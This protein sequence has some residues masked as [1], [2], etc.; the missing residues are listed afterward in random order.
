MAHMIC[1]S[2]VS[3]L[4][5]PAAGSSVVA[6]QAAATTN[7]GVVVPTGRTAVTSWYDAGLR[8]KPDVAV[9]AAVEPAGEAAVVAAATYDLVEAAAPAGFVWGGTFVF[10][11][12]DDAGT[13]ELI[14]KV[15]PM[16]VAP[17]AS[18]AGDAE[19]VGFSEDID[20]T[21]LI[22]KERIGEGTQ[23]EVLL[24]E[25]PGVGPVAVKVGFKE[26]AIARE[27]V[28]LSALCGV[29][30]FPRMLA[31][32]T[33]DVNGGFLV[34]E[35]LGSS[36]D[37]IW[38]SK[39]RRPL[40]GQTLLRVGR[41]VLRLL[42]RLHLA[43][44]VHNDVKPANILLGA[45]SSTLQPTRLHLIDFGS[46]TRTQ[47][48]DVA[49]NSAAE[50]QAS[51]EEESLPP[52]ADGPIGTAMFASITADEGG[53]T[54]PADDL[55]SLV[56]ALT[57]LAAGRLPW[58]SK[59]DAETV[60]MKRELLVSG[61]VAADLCHI[62]DIHCTTAVSALRALSAELRR[63]YEEGPSASAPVDY[64]ACLAAL[65]GGGAVDDAA[66]EAEDALS[67]FSFM[68]ALGGDTKE[69]EAV[70]A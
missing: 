46:C 40:S 57:Y 24:G 39:S 61:D 26:F 50:E 65:G 34:V 64:A 17:A 22:L 51:E 35:L 1:A 66:E 23:S 55:E 20:L 62:D 37:D 45:G 4:S 9:P 43:G 44:F 60:A 14:G 70:A 36:L 31:K 33:A 10:D 30:G 2:A 32:D 12:D 5:A 69:E 3:R 63:Y 19:T 6:S 7:T 16:K 49:S 68:A 59:S 29:P 56:Y 53:R 38:Q 58:Q 41:G 21:R 8:L 11:D 47:R 42:R 18:G 27:A 52:L 28:V 25:L 13:A 48:H 15:V 67:E 54:G